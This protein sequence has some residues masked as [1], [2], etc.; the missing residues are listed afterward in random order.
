MVQH[1]ALS[2]SEPASSV[3]FV[4]TFPKKNSIQISK[5]LLFF[6]KLYERS[7][8]YATTFDTKTTLNIP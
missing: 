5:E 1:I 7:I 8:A 3:Q 2:F 6:Q 4:K